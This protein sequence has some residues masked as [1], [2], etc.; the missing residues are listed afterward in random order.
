MESLCARYT[1]ASIVS[2]RA[3]G[4]ASFAPEEDR[5]STPVMNIAMARGDTIGSSYVALATW[6]S[7]GT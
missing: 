4:D 2:S 3:S 1:N 6:H 5:P 7:M